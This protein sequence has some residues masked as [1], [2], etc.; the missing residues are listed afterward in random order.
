MSRVRQKCCFGQNPIFPAPL[1][2]QPPFRDP[3]PPTY[4]PMKPKKVLKKPLQARGIYLFEKVQK[5]IEET[6]LSTLIQIQ[7]RFEFFFFLS[8]LGFVEAPVGIFVYSFIFEA[9]LN[10]IVFF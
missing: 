3:F 4:V 2:T 8:F 1:F 9:F 6:Y 10:S 5:L 7:I